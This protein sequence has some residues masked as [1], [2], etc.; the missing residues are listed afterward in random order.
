MRIAA[1]FGFASE[2]LSDQAAELA[3]RA[4]PAVPRVADS[5]TSLASSSPMSS[6]ERSDFPIS[7]C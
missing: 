7:T 1:A 5:H 3:L 2:A 4:L 6:P